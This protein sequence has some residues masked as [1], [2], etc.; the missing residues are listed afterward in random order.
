MEEKS[1]RSLTPPAPASNKL[2]WT[3]RV[4]SALVVLALLFSAVMKF[5]K[6]PDVE[7]GFAHL[8]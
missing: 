6:P 8:G 1:L 4:I 2:V 5:V 3:G 7:K